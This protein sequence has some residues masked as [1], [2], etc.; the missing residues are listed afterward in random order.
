VASVVVGLLMSFNQVDLDSA[1]TGGD[2][3]TQY[4]F[5]TPEV[6]ENDC[7]TRSFYSKKMSILYIK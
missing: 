2:V 5:L 1:F 7:W 4:V 6:S 3:R